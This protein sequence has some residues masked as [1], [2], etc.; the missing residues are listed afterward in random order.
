MKINLA[1]CLLIFG[2]FL[3]VCNSVLCAEDRFYIG[4][5]GCQVGDRVPSVLTV[6][7]YLDGTFVVILT[8]KTALFL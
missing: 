7:I 3:V 2:S 5:T 6:D 8:P 4:P 1:V